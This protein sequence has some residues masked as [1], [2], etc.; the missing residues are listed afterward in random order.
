LGKKKRKCKTHKRGAV[1]G[2]TTC[3]G[4]IQRTPIPRWGGEEIEEVLSKRAQTEELTG[5]EGTVYGFVLSAKARKAKSEKGGKLNY[6]ISQ[7]EKNIEKGG[8]KFAPQTPKSIKHRNER[9]G[10]MGKNPKT[11]KPSKFTYKKGN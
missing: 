7:E 11:S 1:W 2:K 9:K 8:G 6:N 10:N 3:K 5:G 4:K